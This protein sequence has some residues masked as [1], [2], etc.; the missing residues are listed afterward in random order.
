MA[1]SPCMV[2]YGNSLFL[3]GIRAELVGHADFELSPLRLTTRTRSALSARSAPQPSSLT[4]PPHSRISALRCSRTGQAHL[5]RRGPVER[6]GAGAVGSPGAAR[7]GGW[8][9]AGNSSAWRLLKQSPK[10]KGEA[11]R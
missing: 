7:V 6:P 5:D 1:A 9:A 3:A 2:L 10:T 8:L 4:W 11:P